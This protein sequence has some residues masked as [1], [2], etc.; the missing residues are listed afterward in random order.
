MNSRVNLVKPVDVVGTDLA[1]GA[2][3]PVVLE[4][5]GIPLVDALE[6]LK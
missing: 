2:V 5:V 4:V 3:A 1:S 6:V